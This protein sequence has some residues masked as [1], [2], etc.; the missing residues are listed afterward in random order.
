MHIFL[1]RYLNRSCHIIYALNT[2]EQYFYFEG[3]FKIHNC[4]KCVYSYTDK[5]LLIVIHVSRF[6]VVNYGINIS[7]V[8]LSSEFHNITIK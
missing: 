1:Y 3:S 2:D 8:S 6:C 5:L 7:Q 4:K